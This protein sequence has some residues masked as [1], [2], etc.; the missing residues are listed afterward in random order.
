MRRTIDIP[1]DELRQL[2]EDEQMGIVLLGQRYGCSPTTIS[3]RLHACG[4]ATRPSRFQPS[5]ISEDEFRRLYE[6]EQW[7]IHAMA[8]HF[9]VS[10]STIGNRRR[11]WGIAVRP[12]KKAPPHRPSSPEPM[13]ASE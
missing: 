3:K 13:D 12:K 5:T 2:Y 1:C 10:V 8:R 7:S 4:I 6:V 9:G 11:A